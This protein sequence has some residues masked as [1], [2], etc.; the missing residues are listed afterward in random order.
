MNKRGFTLIELLSVLVLISLLFGLAIPGINRIS[1]NM[2]KKSLNT[3]LKLVEQAGV[4]WGQD[5]KT[6]LKQEKCTIDG[7]SYDCYKVNIRKLLDE[8]YLDGDR[9]DKVYKDPQSGIDLYEN[10][11]IVSIYKK[12]NRVYASYNNDDQINNVCKIR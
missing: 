12:N 10:E 3:K 2:K 9:N 11:C 6:R 1:T 5:N 8:G 4:L 7:T